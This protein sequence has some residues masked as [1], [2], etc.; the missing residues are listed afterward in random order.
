[1][2]LPVVSTGMSGAALARAMMTIV[3]ASAQLNE[4]QLSSALVLY[5][6]LPLPTEERPA[7]S[8]RFQQLCRPDNSLPNASMGSHSTAGGYMSVGPK[9]SRC[10]IRQVPSPMRG[11]YLGSVPITG[12]S[13]ADEPG[14]KELP[15]CWPPLKCWLK[16]VFNDRTTFAETAL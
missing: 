1:M 10:P 5:R 6:L 8:R 11:N 15:R 12:L 3:A 4:R 16:G 9:V 14:N 7:A 2:P 13:A